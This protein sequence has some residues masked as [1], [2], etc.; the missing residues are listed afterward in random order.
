MST[1]TPLPAKPHTTLVGDEHFR[2]L[3]S[4]V[5]DYAIYMLD[6]TG[7]VAS[8]NAGAQ[9]FKGYQPHEI[10]GRHFDAREAR[11]GQGIQAFLGKTN[12]LP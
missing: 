9:R 11:A 12:G 4:S 8:W 1:P 2:L 3:V 7:L 5:T 6:P 10:I